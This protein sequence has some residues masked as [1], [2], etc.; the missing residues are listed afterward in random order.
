[1]GKYDPILNMTASIRA[2]R[3]QA[4]MTQE[5]VAKFDYERKDDGN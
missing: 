4:G 5:E 2:L 3:K 1:M